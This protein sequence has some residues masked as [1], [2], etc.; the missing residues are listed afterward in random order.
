MEKDK[1]KNLMIKI[2]E[3]LNKLSR[4]QLLREARRAKKFSSAIKPI[5]KNPIKYT[6]NKAALRSNTIQTYT[7]PFREC[8][9]NNY[10]S[11]TTVYALRRKQIADEKEA[12][13]NKRKK[14]K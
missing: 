14:R 7:G 8:L 10:I 5:I 3:D 12:K 13:I 4:K 2:T 1:L 9:T 6:L 11:M